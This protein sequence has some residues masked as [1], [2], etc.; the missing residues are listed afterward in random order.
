MHALAAPAPTS[1]RTPNPNSA[2]NVKLTTTPHT[3]TAATTASTTDST[4]R[5]AFLLAVM[6]LPFL[7]LSFQRQLE[8]ARRVAIHSLGRGASVALPGSHCPGHQHLGKSFSHAC[9]ANCTRRCAY[10]F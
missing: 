7:F 3:T 6:N 9:A 8:P 2:H 5:G 1:M 4:G 10:L